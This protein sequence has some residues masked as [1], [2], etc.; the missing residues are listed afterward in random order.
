MRRMDTGAH[1]AQ[2]EDRGD[3]DQLFLAQA[4]RRRSSVLCLLFIVDL[5]VGLPVTG[6]LSW[7]RAGGRSLQPCDGPA[8]PR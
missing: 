6:G 5:K 4:P 8:P 7:C 1:G 2:R 3:G